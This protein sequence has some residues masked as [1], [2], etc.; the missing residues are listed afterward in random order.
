[1]S[2][3]QLMLP[4]KKEIELLMNHI[5]AGNCTFVFGLPYI[6][7]TVLAHSILDK[8]KTRD[9]MHTIYIDL[10]DFQG[11]TT[12]A[13][14]DTIILK[15][16]EAIP[17]DG[18]NPTPAKG[19]REY[20]L[21]KLLANQHGKKIVILLDSAEC[22]KR[23]TDWDIFLPTIR[24]LHVE[25]RVV[26]FLFSRIRPQGFAKDPISSPGINIFEA[27]LLKLDLLPK[28]FVDKLS[29][30]LAAGGIEVE[31]V[32]PDFIRLHTGGHPFLIKTYI[33][34]YQSEK[35]KHTFLE[36]H[37]FNRLVE[38]AEV[39]LQTFYKELFEILRPRDH[40]LIAND[41][42]EGKISKN[43]DKFL[44]DLQELGI[45]RQ[46]D[47]GY[48]LFSI[49]AGKYFQKH[50]IEEKK[51]SIIASLPI[52]GTWWAKR[53]SSRFNTHNGGIGESVDRQP[54]APPDGKKNRELY[55]NSWALVVGINNYENH[56]IPGLAFAE[57]DAEAVAS[58]LPRLGFP[59]ENIT[60]LLGSRKK[61]SR[62][63]I[64][65]ILEARL[66]PKIE[67]EDRFLFY[68]AGHGV[69]YESNRHR[70]GYLL[71]Q[72][73]ELCGRWPSRSEPFL[74]KMPIKALEMGQFLDLVKSL[75]LKHKLLLI[76]SCFSGFM[77]YPRRGL[78]AGP[79][80]DINKKLTQWTR[81]PVTQIITAGRSGQSAY[82]K[83]AYQH[84][85]FTWYLLKGLEGNADTRG[86]GVISFL[87][88]AAYICDRVSQEIAVEQD[89]QTG[90]CEGE[91][92][93]IFLY[94]E[95]NRRKASEALGTESP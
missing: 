82:E 89:P 67:K 31:N 49:G 62:E 5:E 18:D 26:F 44:R 41:I 73:S 59:E 1:M 3:A 77:T 61:V 30:D 95:E 12:D 71:M 53:K 37:D 51:L 79:A 14:L 64:Q 91:G 40:Q 94:G 56:L 65:E 57:S 52:I 38:K 80:S 45:L 16:R 72:D 83:G 7:K 15:T 9:H 22:I 54:F 86:D 50:F 48:Q 19:N 58:F 24:A 70:R 6:G 39:R 10:K 46:S 33:E 23:L 69:S 27:N 87:D 34:I 93:F 85:V 55:N 78:P 29:K 25:S 11:H 4:R 47:E 92:Q 68:F 90:T 20:H 76:D 75:P 32:F 84:G 43:R 74:K 35:K 2:E 60:L 13:V 21:K 42:I 17:G 8:L 28:H 63:T 36:E 88:L 66:N 81:E